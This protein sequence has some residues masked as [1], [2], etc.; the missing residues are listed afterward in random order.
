MLKLFYEELGKSGINLQ[1]DDTKKRV[2]QV[3]FDIWAHGHLRRR[4]LESF[5]LLV[6]S[7]PISLII[8]IIRLPAM[9]LRSANELV[10]SAI[11]AILLTNI[12]N[13]EKMAY[14][15]ILT[16]LWIK[17]DSAIKLLEIVVYNI[18]DLFLFG[19]L[20]RRRARLA[21]MLGPASDVQS[22]YI[23]I[24]IC[25]SRTLTSG[26][27]PFMEEADTVNEVSSFLKHD[28]TK[29][30]DMINSYWKSDR[31]KGD[32]WQNALRDIKQ[33]NSI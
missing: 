10:F 33:E 27:S 24:H 32:F 11:I 5:G 26:S 20:T 30:E 15:F 12:F 16:V 1:S 17:K 28:Q 9:I 21:I 19:Y 7:F 8:D 13:I 3:M 6:M 2:E 22:N 25:V 29:L 4:K 23:N 14:V 31:D 18:L